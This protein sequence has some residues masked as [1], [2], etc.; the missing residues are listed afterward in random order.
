MDAFVIQ[1]GR[2][3][4]GTVEI[5]GSK[6]AALP[7]MAAALAT[8]QPVTLR[9]V[10]DLADIRS[11]VKLLE[12]LGVEVQRTGATGSA[13]GGGDLAMHRTDGTKR[14]AHYDIVRTMRAGICVLGPLLGRHGEARVSMPGGCAIG[15]RPVDLHL[16]GLRAMGAQI[17]LDAGYITATGPDGSGS[18]LRGAH[19]FLGGPMGSTVLGTANVMTAAVLAEGTTVIESAACEPEVVDLANL[20]TAMGA[21]ISGA[22][23]P[24]ITIEGV[25]ALSGAD[26]RIIPD[27]IE[28]GTYVCAAAITGGDVTL[29]NFPTAMLTA[30]LDRL[31]IVG[32]TLEAEAGAEAR[33]AEAPDRDRQSVRVVAQRRLMPVQIVTQ[34]HPGFPTDLQAQVMAL[35]TLADGNSIITEKIFPDRFMHAPELARM[36]ADITRVGASA[37]ITGTRELVG[38]PVM[39]SDLR[40]S[41]GLVIAGLAARG[42]TTVN[43]VYHLDRGYERMELTLQQLGA[44]IERVDDSKL[45]VGG[46]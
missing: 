38:A 28:A 19:V 34:P 5:H 16:R 17:E 3:L 21:Q 44:Q 20:L 9:G 32:V 36:G 33:S 41:A 13:C 40:A 12:S 15:D 31:R 25:D 14:I 37:I 6:N 45:P 39:A 43:R 23:S 1:G 46:V 2:P 24:T 35:L 11:M 4:R 30:F 42:T 29:T 27:R 7:L 10:P 22:G 8:D 26:H 18:R